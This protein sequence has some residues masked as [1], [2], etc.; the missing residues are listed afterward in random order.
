MKK[1]VKIMVP[2]QLDSK[3]FPGKV[4]ADI[5]GIPMLKRVLTQC[6]KAAPRKDIFVVT[7]DV[8]IYDLAGEWG[9]KCYMS[10]GKLPNGTVAIASIAESLD[11][12]YIVNIQSDHPVIPPDLIRA[13]VHNI[14]NLDADIVT[15]VYKI[16]DH[17]DI[18]DYSV[19]KV[20]RDLNGWALYFSRS[21]IPCV[22]D[23]K[24]ENWLD[25]F[26]YW[27]HYGIY[28]YKKEVLLKI[29]QLSESYLESA[30]GLE[31]LRF[32][33]NGIKILTFETRY[34]QMSVDTARDIEKISRYIDV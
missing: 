33:Q 29:D 19:G 30:E 34:H 25:A 18:G 5:K 21:P 13:I 14:V 17:Q 8:K 7:P 6:N 22:R 11:C 31:Q 24:Y 23:V 1:S 32:L 2:A 20:V 12:D 16:T 9:Y 3:R 27:G 4:L 26:P 28:G 10:G 15:P